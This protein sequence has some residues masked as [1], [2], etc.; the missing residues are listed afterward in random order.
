MGLDSGNIPRFIKEFQEQHFALFESIRGIHSEGDRRWYTSILFNRLVTLYFLQRRGDLDGGDRHYLEH[1]LGQS[2][3]RGE[4]RFFGEFLSALFFEGLGKP[5]LLRNDTAR[6]FIGEIPDWNGSLFRL[7]SLERQYPDIAISD[8][9]FEELFEWFGSYEWHLHD[10][11]SDGEITPELWGYAWEGYVNRD[12]LGGY[13][14]PPEIAEYLCDR[15]VGKAIVDGVNRRCDRA[16]EDFEELVVHLDSHIC[17]ELVR[18]I[19]PELSVLDPACGSGSLLLAAMKM[20]LSVYVAAIEIL[21]LEGT[22]ADREW[23]RQLQES[24]SS[25]PYI[26]QKRIAT[27]NLYGVD[28]REEAIE[29]CQLRFYLEFIAQIDDV[30]ELEP[31]P[32]LDFNLMAGNSL[33]GWIRVDEEGFDAVGEHQQGNLLQPLVADSYRQI[34]REKNVRLEQYKAQSFILQEAQSIPDEMN[35]RFVRDRITEVDRKAQRK[36]DR[37]L[38]DEF[39]VRLG[40]QY[41][42]FLGKG[43]PKKRLLTLADIEALKPFHWGYQFNQIVEARG[44]FDAIITHPPWGNFQPKLTKFIAKYHTLFKEKGILKSRGKIDRDAFSLDREVDWLWQREREEYKLLSDYYRLT[45]RYLYSS[46]NRTYPSLTT[47]ISLDNLFV[48]LCFKLIRSGGHAALAIPTRFYGNLESM[49]L[50]EMLL[51]RTRLGDILNIDRSLDWVGKFPEEN[52]LSLLEFQK[53]GRTQK[54][55]LVSEVRDLRHLTQH[56][57]QSALDTSKYNQ[58]LENAFYI[59]SWKSRRELQVIQKMTQFPIVSEGVENGWSFTW[60]K[61]SHQTDL[62]KILKPLDR[63]DCQRLYKANAIEQFTDFPELIKSKIT[64]GYSSQLR[65]DNS[66]HFGYR[67]VLKANTR[68]SDPRTVMATLIPKDARCDRSLWVAKPNHL[69]F[70]TTAERLAILAILNSFVFD[71][72]LRK[73][74]VDRVN[75]FYLS[76]LRMPRIRVGDRYFQEIVE[77]S[78]KLVCLRAEFDELAREAGLSSHQC[79]VTE[80]A[81]RDRLRAELDAIVAHLYGL[82]LAEFQFVLSTFPKVPELPKVRA[83]EAMNN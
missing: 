25:L 81:D 79:G 21:R 61:D 36:L 82:T 6:G 11:I 40:I 5:E 44:G 14:T 59:L 73:I 41:P 19:L 22:P 57:H 7:H 56:I 80:K 34:L 38:L 74:I 66:F 76:Q 63:K 16:F 51:D 65:V 54:F 29:I 15:S 70:P 20:L 48:E 10:D 69:K 58:V 64:S 46:G 47:N 35:P 31:L 72:Y 2:Q 75:L 1:K 78:A 45:D 30:R 50:R 9:A 27:E 42:Q 18:N 55:T 12:R 24:G 39:S 68:K 4:N 43:K 67:L 33:I 28:I 3:L 49:P 32:N 77:R 26:L 13:F 71:F 83:F 52:S 37:L 17:G 8:R 23:L 60:G 53:D 62:K